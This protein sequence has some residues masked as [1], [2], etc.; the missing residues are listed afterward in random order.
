MSHKFRALLQNNAFRFLS[1]DVD[2]AGELFRVSGLGPAVLTVKNDSDTP[3]VLGAYLLDASGTDQR[4]QT[5]TTSTT[6]TTEASGYTGNASTLAFS[7]QTINNTP[8]VPRSIRLHPATSGVDLIDGGDGVFYTDDTDQDV[9]GTVDYFTGAMTLA[10]PTGKA[11]DGAINVAYI[12]EDATLGAYGR[13]TF[14]WSALGADQ[15][16]VIGGACSTAADSAPVSAE[17]YVAD[18]CT[19]AG[20]VV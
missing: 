4:A 20:S 15:I 19:T 2:A 16:L 8:V 11:P 6:V 14:I 18:Q 12:Y 1:S 10:Y 5:T 17:L 3:C 9:A 7:G 13:K